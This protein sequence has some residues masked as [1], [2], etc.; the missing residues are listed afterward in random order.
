[1][2]VLHSIRWRLQLWHGLIL[3][4]VLAGFG[5][6]AQR[7]QRANELRRVDAELQQRLGVL[8]G[9]LRRPPPG[10]P[11]RDSSAPPPREWGEGDRPERRD[12]RLPPDRMEAFEGEGGG[13]YFVVWSREGH[14][15]GR[16]PSAPSDMALPAR[17]VDHAELRAVAHTREAL[18]EAYTFTPR[19]ECVLAGRSIA[20]ELAGLREFALWLAALGGAVLVLGLGG[21]WWLSSR[22]IRPI[23]D[24]SAAAARIA[25]GDLSHRIDAADTDSELGRLASVLNS[26]FARLQAAFTQQARFTSDAS[27]ELRTP[28][29]VILTQTQ[30]ALTRE[31]SATEYRDTLEACQRAAQRMRRLIESL[32]EL[33]RLDAGQE[34][35]QRAAFDL[36]RVARESIDQLRPLAGERRVVIHCDAPATDCLGD[37]ERIAQVAVNLVA[38]GILHNR[39]G[40]EVRVSTRRENGFAILT[41]SDNGPGIATEELPRLF[42]RFHRADRSRSSATG[43]TGLGLAISKAIVE[44]HGGAITVTSEAGQGAVFEARLPAA[45]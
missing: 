45:P 42:E 29:S 34:P 30:S 33:A 6:T 41:V 16:A 44:A 8:L 12:F 32:L 7:L 14:E 26:T 40:G 1:M 22:A 28:V 39:A 38:N 37:A 43:G 15:L 36:G 13:F 9:A 17:A 4:A 31:R 19:G 11:G 25:T 5:L 2:K 20:P 27:H 21:G 3:V 23:D 18:R 10:G 35:L 24:I